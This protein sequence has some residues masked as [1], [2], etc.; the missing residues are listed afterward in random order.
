[1]NY[2]QFSYPRCGIRTVVILAAEEGAVARH[3]SKADYGAARGNFQKLA[4]LI[5]G[6]AIARSVVEVCRHVHHILHTFM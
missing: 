3:G 4:R 5:D 2:A 6:A 1:M